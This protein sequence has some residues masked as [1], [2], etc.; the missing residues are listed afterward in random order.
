MLPSNDT[1]L[2]LHLL[3]HIVLIIVLDMQT[4]KLREMRLR[5]LD[6]ALEI[7]EDAN[8][9]EEEFLSDALLREIEEVFRVNGVVFTV[10]LHPDLTPTEVHD[11][12]LD[13]QEAYLRPW[14]PKKILS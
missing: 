12:I 10:P 6:R 11:R 7:C 9:R 2:R 8:I 5:G 13:I 3:N 4:D 14:P 1:A